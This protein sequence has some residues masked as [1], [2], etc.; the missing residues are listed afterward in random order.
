[1]HGEFQQHVYSLLSR[2]RSPSL[3]RQFP[4]RSLILYIDTDLINLYRFT[5]QP[6]ILESTVFQFAT[7][8]ILVLGRETL[9]PITR[10][11]YRPSFPSFNGLRI[12]T[13]PKLKLSRNM[14]APIKGQRRRVTRLD[15]KLP[16][17]CI[18]HVGILPRGGF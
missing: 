7:V 15:E 4:S 3:N 12:R 9:A 16:L 14:S 6:L 8:S 17:F 11:I 10:Q 1:M 5:R 18:G 13:R 2:R